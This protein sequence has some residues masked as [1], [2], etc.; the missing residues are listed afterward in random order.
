MRLRD[1]HDVEAG[2]HLL[3]HQ[4][5]RGC[6]ENYLAGREPAVEIIHDHRSN[7]G[8]PQPGGQAHQGVAEE[9]GPGDVQLVVA[10]RAIGGVNPQA[11][12][13]RAEAAV[14]G[15]QLPLG[16]VRR[17]Q[18]QVVIVLLL[19]RLRKG[20]RAPLAAV[21]SADAGA[22]HEARA[23]SLEER[24]LPSAHGAHPQRGSAVPPARL[25]AQPPQLGRPLSSGRRHSGTPGGGTGRNQSG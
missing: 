11:A 10:H 17:H 16:L 23:P 22:S 5:F 12:R 18:Q 15:I 19:Q 14:L 6:H 7:E 3:C 4:G 20:R 13:G 1:T 8:L 24:S 25:A 2:L 21:R 9:R